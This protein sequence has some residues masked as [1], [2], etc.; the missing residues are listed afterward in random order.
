MNTE[1]KVSNAARRENKALCLKEIH[2]AKKWKKEQLKQK[3]KR[4]NRHKDI[5]KK[6]K[7]KCR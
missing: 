1:G 2:Q 7:D 6:K 4:M 5:K 3:V